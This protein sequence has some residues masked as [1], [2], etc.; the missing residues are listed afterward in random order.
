MDELVGR[1]AAQRLQAAG[2]IVG[3]DEELQVSTELLMAIV[4]EA[5]DGGFLDGAVHPFDLT[6][7]RHDAFGAP[8]FLLILSG[9]ALW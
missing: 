5:L 1:E 6:V 4:V 3:I 8:M 7:I 9:S 2:M